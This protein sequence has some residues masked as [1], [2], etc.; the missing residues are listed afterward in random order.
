[1]NHYECCI[2][3]GHTKENCWVLHSHLNFNVEEQFVCATIPKKAPLMQ[4]QERERE[5]HPQNSSQ[6]C[7]DKCSSGF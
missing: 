7:T 1:M 5:I 3:Y 4:K 2:R 6:E